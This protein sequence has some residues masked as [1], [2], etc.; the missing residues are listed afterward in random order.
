MP[1]ITYQ[2]LAPTDFLPLFHLGREV[3]LHKQSSAQDYLDWVSWAITQNPYR[4]D[5]PFGFG[6]F[7]KNQLIG[8]ILRVPVP[9]KIK[10]WTGIAAMPFALAVNHKHP[11]VGIHLMSR[12]IESAEACLVP[13]TSEF[14]VKLLPRK[15]G[16][17][18]PGSNGVAHGVLSLK[19]LADRKLENRGAAGLLAKAVGGGMAAATVL[20]LYGRGQ[21][22]VR[23]R[24]KFVT[25]DSLP[26]NIWDEVWQKIAPHADLSIIKN[27]QYL[28]WRYGPSA[29]LGRVF[30]VVADGGRQGLAILSKRENGNV[31][32]SE[33]LVDPTNNEQ[34]EHLIELSVAV[35]KAIGGVQY[36]ARLGWPGN[37]DLFK[38]CGFEIKQKDQPQF[39]L[40][41]PKDIQLSPDFVGHY[42]H[43]DHRF[44]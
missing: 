3:G 24:T 12:L 17:P 34:I 25:F 22:K 20:K 23:R 4:D 43:G 14:G 33:L 15:G 44:S 27:A 26:A 16:V 37:L 8:G 2:P 28:Q 40:V 39:W 7:E 29:R 19:R 36:Y 5:Q 11:L 21:L 42:S 38:H 13:H 9:A 18:V 30:V 6:A 1:P 32:L 31:E 41:P 10:A 35:A